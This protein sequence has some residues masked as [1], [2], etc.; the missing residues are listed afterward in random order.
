MANDGNKK[1]VFHCKSYNSHGEKTRKIVRELKN[2]PNPDKRIK[3]SAR[4]RNLDQKRSET[5][6]QIDRLIKST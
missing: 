1:P 6:D 3:I 4:L 5:L 2:T